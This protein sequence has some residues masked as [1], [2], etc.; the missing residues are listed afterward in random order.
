MKS[1]YYRSPWNSVVGCG[2][3]RKRKD[4]PIDFLVV[5]VVLPKSEAEPLADAILKLMQKSEAVS[6]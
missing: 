6:A 3:F 2:I 1:E 4:R 5:S